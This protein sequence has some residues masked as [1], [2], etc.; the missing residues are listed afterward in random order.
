M[1]DTP[2]PPPCEHQWRYIDEY[3]LFYCR[4]CKRTESPN[5]DPG[6]AA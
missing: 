5:D 2:T 6:D 3:D 4:K 1:T